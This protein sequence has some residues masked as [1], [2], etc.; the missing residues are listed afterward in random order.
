MSAP[1][2]PAPS[3]KG[4]LLRVWF[5]L[6]VL[7]LCVAVLLLLRRW[8]PDADRLSRVIGIYIA[9][10]VTGLVLLGWLLFWAPF[11]AATRWYVL[12][13]V[14][15][16]A[17]TFAAAFKVEDPEYWGDVVPIFHSRFVS[18][19]T[20]SAGWAALRAWFPLLV[21]AAGGL[22]LL[23]L[24]AWPGDAS[25]RARAVGLWGTAAAV[26]LL[27]LGWGYLVWKESRVRPR[28]A[29]TA[30]VNDLSGNLTTDH[31]E[32]R[33]RHRDGVV[34]GPL[35]ARD[36]ERQPPRELWRYDINPD[37]SPSGHS[38]FAI[39]GNA[40]VTM[41]QRGPREAVVCYDTVTGAERW[42]YSWPGEFSES[43]GGPG[44][45]STPTVLDG[46]V[47]ALGA[48]GKLVCLDVRTGKL[49]WPAP[50]DILENNRNVQWGMSGS[51]L[52]VDN[53]VLVNP[54]V[55]TRGAAGTL[56]AYDRATGKHLW[57]SGRAH[58]GYSSPMLATLAG[59]R[60]VVLFDGE[61]V[62][63][64]DHTDRGK[65]LWRFPWSTQQNINV[66]Q[67]LIVG[68]DRVFISSGYRV[69]CALLRVK[70]DGNRF[71]AEQVWKNDNMRC[72]F[73]SPVLHEDHIYGLD[74]GVLAC[75][76]VS[77]G[78]R[79]WRAGRDGEYRHGQL[80]LSRGLLLITGERGE[81]ALV[82]ATPA[83]FRELGRITAFEDRTWNLPVLANGR[84]YLRN[85]LEMVCY[86][87]RLL[88][89]DV[90]ELG[91]S[92]LRVGRHLGA[93]CFSR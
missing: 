77:D 23:S 72:K 59:K 35:L 22:L 56:A 51:P 85:H 86:D 38:S 8:P 32:Y 6:I 87:L 11:R 30:L 52:V 29:P 13:W 81:L 25:R 1:T 53:L 68:D 90:A 7:V 36:W 10:F 24:R 21:V 16:L 55:Q 14:G 20:A 88:R 82:E 73:T 92:V 15:V 57:S 66:A 49:K 19:S 9:L 54:G 89:F 67:P 26:P 31:P 17:L 40:A 2:S 78:G 75:L 74:D 58:A 33:G 84:A 48:T 37:L 76:R 12:L 34:H 83:A 43:L 63:G 18:A 44:P 61:G 93:A 62:A 80:L 46:E 50:V 69:G 70:R 3:Q 5:P 65:E 28:P 45:R 79:A 91:Q 60:Q 47:F 39:V 71:R 4:S 27:L 41:E 64:Y 42:E